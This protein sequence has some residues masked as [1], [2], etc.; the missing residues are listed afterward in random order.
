MQS[1]NRP[2]SKRPIWRRLLAPAVI[3]LSF[4]VAA[5]VFWRITENPFFFFN[6]GYIGAAVA[7]G[8]GLHTLLPRKRKQ[9]GR[10]VAQLL[11]GLY[12]L[13]YLGLFQGENVQLEGML[14]HLLGGFFAASVIHYLVAK[15]FGP[16]V[17][18]R[19]YCG[20]VC[21]TS[22][23]LDFLPFKKNP[24]GRE[25]QKWEWVRYVHFGLSVALVAILWYAVRYRPDETGRTALIWLITGNVLYYVTGIA[26]A[27]VLKDNRA[28]CKYVCPVTPI[29]KITSRFALMKVE[30]KK[31]L[32][33]GCGACLAA[34]P[35][36][37]NVLEYV[38]NNERVL[39]TECVHCMTCISV[40]PVKA[41]D[42]TFR[43]DVGGRER[44]VRG[45]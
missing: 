38:Q 33:T 36:N 16:L 6:F 39:S 9:E 4:W 43:F 18:G 45:E 37:V 22:M 41:L 24:A 30:G 11:V 15:V 1:E 28:F 17:Y 42:E 20:W 34:C 27:F 12:L 31:D 32:C 10:R 19:G 25:P 8:I 23:I 14:F 2:T 35:M 29:L 26:L 21:W 7:F 13:G 44:L 5:I 3:F 40:C